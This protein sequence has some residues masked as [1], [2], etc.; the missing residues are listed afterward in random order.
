M[1]LNEVVLV[2]CAVAYFY[3]SRTFFFIIQASSYSVLV[4]EEEQND[5]DAL[6]YDYDYSNSDDEEVLDEEKDFISF[7]GFPL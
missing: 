1:F 2:S 5:Q 6:S 7:P 3:N 4:A